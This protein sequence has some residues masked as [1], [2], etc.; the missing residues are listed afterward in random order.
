MIK[1]KIAC[2]WQL[3]A[4]KRSM[5]NIVGATAGANVILNRPIQSETKPV[6]VCPALRLRPR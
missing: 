5:P 3:C 4:G 1:I 6:C 2:V